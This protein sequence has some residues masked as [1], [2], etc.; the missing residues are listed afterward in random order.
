MRTRCSGPNLALQVGK[1]A[2]DAT[3]PIKTCAAC[4]GRKR[5]LSSPWNRSLS[6]LSR[7]RNIRK[8]P[9]TPS[10]KNSTKTRTASMASTWAWLAPSSPFPQGGA[11]RFQAATLGPLVPII[12]KF[13]R[14]LLSTPAHGP[15]RA[16]RHQFNGNGGT[17][18]RHPIGPN[19]PA[20]PMPCKGMEKAK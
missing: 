5:N 7:R 10:K 6:P 17:S 9:M 14:S 1:V 13:I 3:V 15:A 2:S 20:L 4:R 19:A 12:T 8:K 18:H 11:S 16:S